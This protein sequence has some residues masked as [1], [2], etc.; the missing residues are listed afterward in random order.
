MYPY[1]YVCVFMC[2]DYVCVWAMYVDVYVYAC[3]RDQTCVHPWVHACCMH[4]ACMLHACCMHVACMLHA[5]CMHVS[6][7]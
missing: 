6:H 4:V 2:M 1:M 3:S 7:I 5:C